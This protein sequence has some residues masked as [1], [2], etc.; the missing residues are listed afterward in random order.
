MTAEHRTI[1]HD[2]A[3]SHGAI[4]GHMRSNHKQAAAANLR[5]VTG[6]ERGFVETPGI[7]MRTGDE[8]T[9]AV[10][11]SQW[12]PAIVRRAPKGYVDAIAGTRGPLVSNGSIGT[13]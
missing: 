7:E 5:H 9:I 12:F 1:G 8:L 13:K 2:Y 11:A 10:R 3:V 4:V 6:V